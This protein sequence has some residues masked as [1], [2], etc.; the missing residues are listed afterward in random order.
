MKK[1]KF[2]GL[3]VFILS[4]S[5]SWEHD[6][7]VVKDSE[8]NYFLLES[9]GIRNESYDLTPLPKHQIDSLNLNK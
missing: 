7:K 1:I 4:V 5:C 9:N 2:L 6:G 3:I 8:G